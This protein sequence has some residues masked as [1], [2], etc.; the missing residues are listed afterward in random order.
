MGEVCAGIATGLE[1]LLRA[2][3]RIASYS[4]A[5]INPDAHTAT[6]HRIYALHTRYPTLLPTGSTIHW[7][8]RLPFNANCLSPAIMTNFPNGIDIVITG[9]PCQPYSDAGRHKGLTDPRS[10]AL[11][12]VTRLIQHLDLT[13]PQGVGYILENVPGTDKHPCIVKMLGQPL[14]L[15][16]PPCGSGARRETLFWQN[17]APLTQIKSAYSSLPLPTTSIDNRLA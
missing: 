11:L 8:R 7:D 15:D 6:A 5:D 2:G 14:H 17:L 12:Q 10:Q 13:Q 1:A 9:P 3:H 4:W 16:A